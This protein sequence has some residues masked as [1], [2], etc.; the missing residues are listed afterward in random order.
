MS[1]CQPNKVGMNVY[2]C[3]VPIVRIVATSMYYTSLCVA[4]LG[5][6]GRSPREPRGTVATFFNHNTDGDTVV[7][8]SETTLSMYLHCR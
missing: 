7:H 3:G 1:G 8:R 5:V 2:S 6:R 4:T